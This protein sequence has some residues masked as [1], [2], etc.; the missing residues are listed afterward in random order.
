MA[1]LHR[2]SADRSLCAPTTDV[3]QP[4]PANWQQQAEVAAALTS[5][6][7]LLVLHTS[8]VNCP[9]LCAVFQPTFAIVAP[10]VGLANPEL[11]GRRRREVS[12]QRWSG[13]QAAHSQ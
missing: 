4:W 6:D 5:S 10:F 9:R 11:Q 2:S 7:V 12:R 13:Q 3:Q 8:L 1:A